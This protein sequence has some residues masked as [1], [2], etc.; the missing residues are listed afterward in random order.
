MLLVGLQQPINKAIVNRVGCGIV[1]TA[2]FCGKRVVVS[3]LP[4]YRYLRNA[5][6][7]LW[8]AATEIIINVESDYML[9]N[10]NYRADLRCVK[11]VNNDALQ[12]HAFKTLIVRKVR[13][14]NSNCIF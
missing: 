2:I 3:L 14:K 7:Y 9:R 5:V 8:R 1:E 13:A 11:Y 4:A 6:N 10:R 12:E